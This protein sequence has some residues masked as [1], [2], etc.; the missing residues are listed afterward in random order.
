MSHTHIRV[1]KSVAPA[2]PQ[3]AIGALLACIAIG[4]GAWFLW[5]NFRA[6]EFWDT[7]SSSEGRISD[8]RVVLDHMFD[9]TNGGHISYRLEAHVSFTAEGQPQ[10]RWLIVPEDSTDREW[11]IAK[12]SLRPK[13]CRA[14]WPTGHPENAKCRLQ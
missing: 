1:E 11:L 3:Y 6:S 9:G 13:T 14:Y 4:V 5:S 2:K 8:T 7:H 10:D 12:A